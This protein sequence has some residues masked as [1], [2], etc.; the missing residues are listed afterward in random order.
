[1]PR[2]KH[3]RKSK[4]KFKLKKGTVYS[5]FAFGFIVVG[6]ILLLSFSRNGTSFVMINDFLAKYFGDTAVLFLCPDLLGIFILQIKNV[7]IRNQC[8]AWI[9]PLLFVFKCFG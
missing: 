4:I 5:I 6:L 8:V 9:H 7:L 3:Y 2:R 1:M